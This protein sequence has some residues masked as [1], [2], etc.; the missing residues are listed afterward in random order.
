M[1]LDKKD[2]YGQAVSEL[3]NSS[4]VIRT[5]ENKNIINAEFVNE[6]TSLPSQT[7]IDAKAQELLDAYNS[8]E[9]AKIDAKVSGNQ[10]LLDLGL[11]QAEA[12]ALT[13]YT[14]PSEE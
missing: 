14:P 4:A 10:K 6:N 9:Q 13:G 2:F 12:T 11:S 5:D 8:E 3:T 1:N 7:D